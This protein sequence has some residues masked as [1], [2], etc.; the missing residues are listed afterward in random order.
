MLNT[1]IELT[2]TLIW[3]QWPLYKL[4]DPWNVL[5][6]LGCSWIKLI[7]TNAVKSSWHYKQVIFKTSILNMYTAYSSIEEM[8]NHIPSDLK[9]KKIEGVLVDN[10]YV[11]QL[12]PLI[13]SS[14]RTFLHIPLEKTHGILFQELEDDVVNCFQKYGRK[15]KYDPH[16]VDVLESEVV[17]SER[18]TQLMS[19]FHHKR[20]MV[21]C[22]SLQVWSMYL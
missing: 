6:K 2:C 12:S 5:C 9:N 22:L 11:S 10:L 8:I 1:F 3:S 19:K 15:M 13:G 14:L 18:K 20:D 21:I 4:D 16:I 17:S 7:M